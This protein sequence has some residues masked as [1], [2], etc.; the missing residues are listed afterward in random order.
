M[1]NEENFFIGATLR[2]CSTLE[3]EKALWKCLIHIRNYLPADCLFLNHQDLNNRVQNIIAAAT[4]EGGTLS[5]EKV[6]M[7]EDYFKWWENLEDVWIAN[8]VESHYIMKHYLDYIDRQ[9]SYL[10]LRL[11]VGDHFIGS[12]IVQAKGKNRFNESHVKMM[13]LLKEPFGIAMANSLQHRELLKLRDRLKDDNR[14]LQNELLRLSGNDIIGK[15]AGLR[16]VMESVNQVAH[17]ATPVLLIGDTGSGKEIIANAIHNISPRK[18]NPFIKVN[19]GAIPETVIDSELFGHEKGAFTG[20][21]A[22]KRGHFER[23]HE[24]TILLDEIGELPPDAQ[25][26]MLRVLQDK[27]IY[28]VGGSKPVK[29]DIRLIAATHRNLEDLIQKGKFR[30][31]LYYRL[32][33]FPITVPPLNQRKCDIPNLVQHFI[34]KKSREMGILDAIS[35]APGALERMVNYDWRGNV[36]ELENAVERALIIRTGSLIDFPYVLNASPIFDNKQQV[37]HLEQPRP[38]DQLIA[39]EI[40]KVLV[41]TRGKVEGKNGAAEILEVKPNTLRGRMKK[42]GI[43]FG[44]RYGQAL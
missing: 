6:P 20:A 14:H 26:R 19:C 9:S 1:I 43:S 41:L 13:A 5:A 37:D 10:N 25:L 2:I 44:R 7:A 16:G 21:I 23:A 17:L 38:M 18:N 3:I 34:D 32:K 30:E 39:A 33:I 12:L 24:G 8:D 29:V 35:L 40:K 42:L 4:V 36:R 28:R 22:Q 11:I 31:D 27:E 15:D